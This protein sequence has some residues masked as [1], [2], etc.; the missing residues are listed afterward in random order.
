MENLGEKAVFI[1]GASAGIGA[2]CAQAFAKHGATLILTARRKDKLETVAKACAAEGLSEKKIHTFT[3]DVRNRE[4]VFEQVET[5]LKKIPKIDILLNNAGLALGTEKLFEGTPTD[6][7]TMIDT[8]VKGLLYVTRALL[9]HFLKQNAGHIIQL[10]SIAGHETYPGGAVYCATK[11]AVHALNT[12]LLMDLV[13]T[14]IRVSSI[15]PGMVETE[16]SMVRF[17]GNTERAK[18]V[19]ENFR[20]LSASDIA[21]T[22]LFVASC[23]AHMNIREMIV[24]PTHQA[25][26]QVV[27]RKGK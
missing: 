24:L 22:V 7:D 27:H 5:I 14:P 25:S 19:Y 11:A 9:P 23:P 15:D 3:L 12:G 21:Q 8:N 13:D 17:R 16:F 1:T 2:A 4:Q 18:K 6:W 26:A 20:P 10:G